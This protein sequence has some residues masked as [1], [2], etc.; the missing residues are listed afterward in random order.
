M[1][2]VRW[3]LLVILV[4]AAALGAL[5]TIQN[6]NW[7]AQLSIDLQV[8]AAQLKRP[9]P[10]PHLMWFSFGV[11]LVTGVL[12]LPVLR[13]LFSSGSQGYNDDYTAPTH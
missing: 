11:G 9:M 13:S 7:T 3:I 2:V 4:I 8:Y 1:S 10:V 12:A 5:F 6:A